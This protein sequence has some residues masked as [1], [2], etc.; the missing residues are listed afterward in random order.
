MNP[1]SGFAVRYAI[2]YCESLYEIFYD[3]FYGHLCG[4][5]IKLF[6]DPS[7]TPL[8]PPPNPMGSFLRL[9][10]ATNQR[11]ALG[12]FATGFCGRCERSLVLE[13]GRLRGA[14]AMTRVVIPLESP[15]T[16]Y[17][18]AVEE[19]SRK[20]SPPGYV[21]QIFP[22]EISPSLDQSYILYAMM[23]AVKAGPNFPPGVS[24]RINIAYCRR[25]TLTRTV[26]RNVIFLI[27]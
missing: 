11:K 1:L 13:G 14:T 12:L 5:I 15:A 26:Q 6:S 25:I 19:L 7:F 9:F 27:M 2:R 20:R 24:L 17:V 4:L 21:W 8:N 16:T 3:P 10:E 18:G 22:R 23:D